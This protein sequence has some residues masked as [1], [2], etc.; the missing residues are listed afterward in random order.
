M[1]PPFSQILMRELG[2][3]GIFLLINICS[4]LLHLEIS[5]NLSISVCSVSTD[6]LYLTNT[7]SIDHY[8]GNY[9]NFEKTYEELTKNKIREYEAQ[10]QLRDH[11]QV[12]NYQHIEIPEHP[13][14]G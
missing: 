14:S 10:Q 4:G 13:V 1:F 12:R 8:K 5:V 7:K 11:T 2:D 6:V 3:F 9:D